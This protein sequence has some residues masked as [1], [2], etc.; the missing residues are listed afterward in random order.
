MMEPASLSASSGAGMSARMNSQLRKIT[1]KVPAHDLEKAQELTGEGVTETIRI[2][3]RKRASIRAQN[4]LRK[5]EGKV[6]FSMTWQE[7]KY[8]RE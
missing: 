6:K 2:A 7:L 4:E 3:L 5:L 1:V 8:D